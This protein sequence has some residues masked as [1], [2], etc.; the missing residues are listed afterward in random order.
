MPEMISSPEF[1]GEPN[2]MTQYMPSIA[3]S[4]VIVNAA[5]PNLE[6]DGGLPWR[7]S[8]ALSMRVSTPFAGSSSLLSEDSLEQRDVAYKQPELRA[9]ARGHMSVYKDLPYEME[10]SRSRPQS[11]TMFREDEVLREEL[12]DPLLRKLEQVT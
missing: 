12:D 3:R 6:Q 11:R 7:P 4:G 5:F 9:D 8:S 1:D 10:G 2:F